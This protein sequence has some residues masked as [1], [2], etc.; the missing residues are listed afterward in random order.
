MNVTFRGGF[1]III[2]ITI[3]FKFVLSFPF[4]STCVWHHCLHDLLDSLVHQ[5]SHAVPDAFAVLQCGP[6]DLPL[7][8]ATFTDVS[9][10]FWSPREQHIVS[11]DHRSFSQQTRAL[12]Q[13]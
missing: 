1:M 2:S 8:Q 13:L 5:L 12:Q 7:I 11:H 4:F 9:E 6:V 3:F 10:E